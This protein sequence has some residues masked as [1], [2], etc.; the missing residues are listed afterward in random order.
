MKLKNKVLKASFFYQEIS[1][2]GKT[3]TFL[4]E[5]KRKLLITEKQV[6]ILECYGFFGKTCQQKLVSYTNQTIDLSGKPIHWFL[7]D[8]IFY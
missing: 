8:L 3:F 5:E 1:T 6:G 4:E 7:Y 2:Y